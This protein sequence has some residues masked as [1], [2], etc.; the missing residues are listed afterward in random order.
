M[1]IFEK[2]GKEVQ[3]L[4]TD[5]F[6]IFGGNEAAPCSFRETSEDLIPLKLCHPP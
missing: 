6:L 3:S 4:V 5:E 2:T 1:I